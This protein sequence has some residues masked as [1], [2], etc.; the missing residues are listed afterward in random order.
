MKASHGKVNT[1]AKMPLTI[2]K[3]PVKFTNSVNIFFGGNS[4]G[5]FE[6]ISSAF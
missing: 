6:E 1:D 2:D 3:D 4:K 5:T